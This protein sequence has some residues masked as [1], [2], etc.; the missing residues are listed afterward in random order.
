MNANQIAS[1]ILH[2]TGLAALARATLTRRGKFALNLHGVSS[3]R[4]AD[5]PKDLQPHHSA[6]EFRRALE[7]LAPRFQFLT[8]EEFLY[9]NESGILL[10]FDDGHANNLLHALPILKKFN[11]QGLFFVS[12]QHV[13]NPR[14]WLSF[15][16]A[17]ARRGWGA[18]SAVP[19]DFARD[20]YDGLSES[21]LA[22]LAASPLAVIG[23]HTVTHPNLTELPQAEVIAE[24][25]DSKEYLRRVSG[26]A[27]NYFAYPYGYYNRA[28]ANAARAAG[29]HAAFAVNCLNVGAP[30]FEIPRVGIYDCAPAYLN[31][32]LSGLHRLPLQEAILK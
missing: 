25:K 23:A 27:I 1:Q 30:V 5:I 20:C 28:V 26:Q 6:E 3:K 24:M 2:R 17:D 22:E 18:E 10:T 21:Q 7:W 13:K 19:E 9:T 14:N 4:Y 11:A 15:T 8:V 16:R 31:V 32:K 29:F 12:T